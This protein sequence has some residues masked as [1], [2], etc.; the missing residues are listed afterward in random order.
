[1]KMK[2]LEDYNQNNHK[3]KE[4]EVD[5]ILFDE[6]FAGNFKVRVVWE[7]GRTTYFSITWFV[8]TPIEYW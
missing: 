7:D 5:K 6:V 8:K 2:L 1:M 4:L 3:G